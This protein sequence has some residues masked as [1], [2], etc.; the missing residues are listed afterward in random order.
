MLLIYAVGSAADSKLLSWIQ[1]CLVWNY[2][3]LG[4][5]LKWDINVWQTL[6]MYMHNICLYSGR[7]PFVF[8][9]YLNLIQGVQQILTWFAH[10]I[11]YVLENNFEIERIYYCDLSLFDYKNL[12]KGFYS[13]VWLLKKFQKNLKNFFFQKLKINILSIIIHLG[14]HKN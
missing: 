3:S 12:S 1:Y 6:D 8:S 11:A 10:I 2:V 5:C 7:A 14:P 13:K 4:R 9:I